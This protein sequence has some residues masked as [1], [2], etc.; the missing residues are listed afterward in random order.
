MRNLLLIFSFL[1]LLNVNKSYAQEKS[2]D[3]QVAVRIFAQTKINSILIAPQKGI[4]Q[5][6]AD[7][8]KIMELNESSVIK[9]TLLNDVIEVKAFENDLGK[10]KTINLVSTDEEKNLKIKVLNPDRKARFYDDDLL[11][12]IIENEGLKLINNTFIDNYIAGVS[13]AEAGKSAGIEFYKVQSVL[14]RTYALAHLY[15]HQPEGF[16]LCDQV[17]CQAFHGKSTQTPILNAVHS[18]RGEVVVDQDLQLIT[19]AFHSNSGG[20]TANSE[21]VWGASTTYLK[22]VIDTF[23]LK[24]PNAYWQK[25]MPVDEWLNYLKSKHKYPVNNQEAKDVALHFKQETRKVNLIYDNIKI[26]LKN[27]RTDLKLKSTFFSVELSED[28]NSI[29]LNGRG[30]GHGIGM[31]Q[32]GA[33]NMTKSGYDYKKVLNFYY[34]NIHIIHLRELHFFKE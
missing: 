27:I 29:T 21:D 9:A 11:I 2:F 32:E 6:I 18:T 16:N 28:G 25:K 30:F 5:L 14:A 7:G 1:L 13:E 17:H 34:K 24:M 3:E 19:A 26:P 15:K 23:S 33:I 22:S 12:S 4:Y 8:N 10:F 20:Q 31:C